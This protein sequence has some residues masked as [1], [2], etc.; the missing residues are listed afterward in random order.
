MFTRFSLVVIFL[1]LQFAANADELA[2]AESGQ[3]VLLRD[4]GSWSLVAPPPQ[5]N[6]GNPADTIKRKC[7]AEWSTNFQMQAFCIQNQNEALEKLNRGKPADISQSH[8]S[9]VSS[10]CAT[11]WPNDFHARIL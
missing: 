2:T 6:A 3:R 9:I 11:E 10:S 1:L 5:S 8:F 4:N 7:T